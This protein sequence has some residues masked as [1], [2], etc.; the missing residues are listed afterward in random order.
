[1]QNVDKATK[2][3]AQLALDPFEDLTDTERAVLLLNIQK[4]YIIGHNLGVVDDKFATHAADAKVGETVHLVGEDIRAFAAICQKVIDRLD[5][6]L[7]G[8]PSPTIGDDPLLATIKELPVSPDDPK[9]LMALD[10]DLSLLARKIALWT[11][12]QCQ[13]GMGNRFINGERLRGASRRT[14]KP[15]LARRSRS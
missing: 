9:N 5:A 11:A 10:V 8:S 14:R 4:R 6:W 1:L 12:E 13:D 3:F 2:R 15:S 7:G